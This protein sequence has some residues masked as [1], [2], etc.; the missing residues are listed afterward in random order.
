MMFKIGINK[1]ATMTLIVMCFVSCSAYTKSYSLPVVYTDNHINVRSSV[2]FT[3]EES[4]HLGDLLHLAISLEYDPNR[5]RIS[6]LNETLL[7]ESWRESPWVALRGAPQLERIDLENGL[8]RID[9]F[10][11]FQIVDCPAPG[12][13]CPGGKAYAM[14]DIT[15][16]VD[17]I[18]DNGRVVST[19]DVN[20]RPSPGFVGLPSALMLNNNKLESFNLY[21]PGRAFGLPIPATVNTNPS[22]F[23]FILGLILVSVMVVAPT[24]RSWLRHRVSTQIGILGNRW[25]R[26]LDRLQ[27][28]SL[29][30]EEF[31][32]GVRVA[33]TWYCHDEY[34]INPVHWS[35]ADDNTGEDLQ[36]L[37]TLYLQATQG[38]EQSS[39]QRAAIVKQ[40]TEN[41]KQS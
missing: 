32:E 17:L 2:V 12:G 40:L 33:I 28:E 1:I 22:L 37:K 6:N 24:A 3:E 21:F 26:V 4:F 29:E 34:K 18:D 5:V 31:S 23:L 7:S 14:T 36:A 19:T 11:Q 8:T 27:E 39:E 35:A 9:A 25:E 16:G 20:F 30:G 38:T 10:Y 41:F 15:L 13:Q